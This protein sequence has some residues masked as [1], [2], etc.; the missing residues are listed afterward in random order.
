MKYV[1]EFRN[2]ELAP[3]WTDAPQGAFILLTVTRLSRKDSSGCMTGLN[4]KSLPASSGCHSVAKI[5]CR[6]LDLPDRSR[7]RCSS[8]EA[9]KRCC[10]SSGR[11]TKSLT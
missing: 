5:N 2:A 4:L 6:R 11:L 9:A 1:D 10:S 7:Q 3:R 8:R